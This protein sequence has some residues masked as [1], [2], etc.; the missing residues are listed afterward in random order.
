MRKE[1]WFATIILLLRG[2]NILIFYFSKDFLFYVFEYTVADIRHIRRGI[3]SHYRWLWA[4]MWLLRIELTTSGRALSALNHWAISL[5]PGKNILKCIF[6]PSRWKDGEKSQFPNNR[7]INTTE[8]ACKHILT[9]RYVGHRFT[10]LPL[11][12]FL[13]PPTHHLLSS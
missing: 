10:F 2:K 11:S 12:S 3:R 13:L 7:L 1:G 9:L 8:C 6:I 5:A 4:T